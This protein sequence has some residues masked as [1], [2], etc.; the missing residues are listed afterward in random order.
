MKKHILSSGLLNKYSE[1]A[2]SYKFYYFILRIPLLAKWNI[3]N[4]FCKYL[5]KIF[6]VTPPLP[7]VCRVSFN[8]QIYTISQIVWFI[9]IY[10][11]PYKVY[12][13]HLANYFFQTGF[14]VAGGGFPMLLILMFSL[15]SLTY[16]HNLDFS[17]GLEWSLVSHPFLILILCL[18]F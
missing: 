10:Y 12:H 14:F 13:L 6:Q 4:K 3:A 11:T 7:L 5:N 2:W 16:F 8:T 15:L 18:F 17:L 1:K 9:R